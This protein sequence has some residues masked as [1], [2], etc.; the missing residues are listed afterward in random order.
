MNYSNSDPL[1]MSQ[2]DFVEML[3]DYLRLSAGA[4]VRQSRLHPIA[5][6]A[7]S[8]RLS[9][10]DLK[11]RSGMTSADFASGMESGLSQLMLTKF[12]ARINEVQSISTTRYVDNFQETDFLA[13]SLSEPAEEATDNPDVPFLTTSISENV[14]TG[15]LRSFSGRLRFSR[16]VW[17][18]WSTELMGAINEYGSSIFP[19]L[20]R[21]VLTET[22]EAGTWTTGNGALSIS[23]LNDAAKLL[24]NSTNDAGQKSNLPIYAIAIPT[25]LEMTARS[26]RQTFGWPDLKIVVLPDLTSATTWY[27]IAD[28]SLSAPIIRLVLRA[29]PDPRVYSNPRLIE[30]AEF[31]V[32]HDF[33]F[34]EM[35]GVP[36]VV[37]MTL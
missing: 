37:V 32:Q 14:R 28:P 20:E 30:G 3:P 33:N 12:S 15:Q 10:Q 13:V 21:K 7:Y 26:I 5:A 16:P 34:V 11:M 2:N 6:A 35:S 17:K 19:G 4:P 1:C 36:G 27:A 25:E 24:R 22:L 29:S 8:E 23:S 18:T 31:L 9:L